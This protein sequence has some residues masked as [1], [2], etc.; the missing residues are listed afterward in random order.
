[1]S[2][3]LA[4]VFNNHQAAERVRTQLIKDGFPTDRVG[5]TPPAE[6]G[7]AG[8]TPADQVPEKLSQYFHLRDRQEV[9]NSGERVREDCEGQP[10][11]V[12]SRAAPSRVPRI[13]AWRSRAAA[14]VS[15]CASKGLL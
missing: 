7:Q 8:L 2:P 6:L 12:P 10:L 1:M 4:A 5:L 15:L 9:M 3:V 13:R 14:M 11:A